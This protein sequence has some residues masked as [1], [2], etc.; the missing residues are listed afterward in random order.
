MKN[1]HFCIENNIAVQMPFRKLSKSRQQEFNP[2]SKR[3]RLEQQFDGAAY[4]RR[5]LIESVNSAIK[6][7]LGSYVCS[8]RADNQQKTATIKAIA[9]NLEQIGRTIKMWL[10]IYC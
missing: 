6:R 9:Y 1:R 2:Q 5:S 8:R 4:R 10:F 7:T 3:Q